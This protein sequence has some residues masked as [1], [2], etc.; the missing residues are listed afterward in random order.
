RPLEVGDPVAEEVRPVP[1]TLRAE[2]GEEV[3][4]G[5][6]V[7]RR[8]R[9]RPRHAEERRQEREGEL[10][11][12]VVPGPSASRRHARNIPASAVRAPAR[13]RPGARRPGCPR[14]PPPPG[15]PPGPPPA[16][17]RRPPPPPAPLPIPPAARP[18][19]PPASLSCPRAPGGCTRWTFR[20][21]PLPAACS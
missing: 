11:H 14:P 10:L 19:A 2:D 13:P 7:D 1:E 6:P 18:P 5:Q 16:P 15:P 17:P 21:P 20:G 3:V 9:E 8:E 12:L 4:H